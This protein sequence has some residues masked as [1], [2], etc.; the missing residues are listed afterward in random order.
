MEI[1]RKFLIKNLPDNLSSYPYHQIE[2][3]YLCTAPVVRIRRQ[4]EEYYLT[5]KS[6]G[7]MVREEYNLPLTIESYAHLLP[8]IDGILISKKRYL[9]PIESD[10]TIE[11]DIFEGKLSPL[12]LAEV[13]FDTEEQ[14][15][16][17]TPPEWFGEDVT[18][19]MDYHNSVLSQQ[20]PK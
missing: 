13:E 11:L 18:Y 19:S 10:L 9:I 12:I 6:K 5:Y 15:K 14:A 4:D 20:A 2:Q 3:G 17:F 1:E 7:L 8:K 16:A